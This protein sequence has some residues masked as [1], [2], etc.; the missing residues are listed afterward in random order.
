VIGNAV[1][2]ATVPRAEF[3]WALILPLAIA[4]AGFGLLVSQLN[5]YTLGPMSEERASEAAGVNSAAGSFGLSLGLALAGA[6]ML[7]TLATTFTA[8]AR[9]SAVLVP[10]D[11][12]R[13]AAALEHD[14]EV[15]SNT[16]LGELVADEPPAVRDEI[17]RINTEARPPALQIALLVPLVAGVLG[18]LVSFPM[19]RRPDPEQSGAAESVLGG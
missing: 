18:L 8:E 9:S 2:I 7:A 11:Q 1:L 19:S 12:A 3:G 5:A 17:V 15:M 16:G 6:V 13:V 10:A 14:A 4:G